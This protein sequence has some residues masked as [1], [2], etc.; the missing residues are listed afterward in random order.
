MRT[1]CCAQHTYSTIASSKESRAGSGFGTREIYACNNC[2]AIKVI[3]RMDSGE[4]FTRFV[5]PRVEG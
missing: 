1:D 4:V 5:Q 3:F 2:L